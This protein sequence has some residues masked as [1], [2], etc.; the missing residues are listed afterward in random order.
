MLPIEFQ[1]PGPAED[2]LP[3]TLPLGGIRNIIVVL[4]VTNLI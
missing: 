2:S 3:A 1:T 4:I